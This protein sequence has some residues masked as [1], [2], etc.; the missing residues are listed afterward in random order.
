MTVLINASPTNGLQMTSDGSGI[1]KLQSAG[2]TTNALAWVNFN[3]VTTVT[4]K[5]SYNISSVTRSSTGTY[6]LNFSN[7]MID[8]NYSVIGTGEIT[9]GTTSLSIIVGKNNTNT[10]SAATIQSINTGSAVLDC[11]F[12]SVAVFGN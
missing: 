12:V 5:S 9:L 4:I 11:P 3:G 6:V 2:V 8:A 7:A 1:V 10:T